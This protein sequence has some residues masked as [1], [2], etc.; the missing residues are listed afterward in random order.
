MPASNA[1]IARAWYGRGSKPCGS[2]KSATRGLQRRFLLRRDVDL[3]VAD[4]GDDLDRERLALG[5]VER[6]ATLLAHLLHEDARVLVG[7]PRELD[8]PRHAAQ[9][10]E[11]L[12]V[13]LAQH[14]VHRS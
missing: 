5:E 11:G 12:D 9:D 2:L 3:L 8:E 7:L 6:H 14:L 10:V 13:A 4:H 1:A